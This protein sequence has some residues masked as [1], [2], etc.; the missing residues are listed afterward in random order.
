MDSVWQLYKTGPWFS[1]LFV[2]L[3]ARIAPFEWILPHLPPQGSLLEVGCGHGLLTNWIQ[4]HYPLCRILGTDVNPQRIAA[5]RQTLLGRKNIQFHIADGLESTKETYDCILFFDL[6]HH[7]EASQHL[8]S[9]RKARARL[10]PGGKIIVKEMFKERSLSHF[11]GWLHDKIVTQ[12]EK[13]CYRRAEEWI[14]L[15]GQAGL[16]LT[17]FRKGYKFWYHQ[18]LFVFEPGK[19]IFS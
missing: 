13:T 19:K 3:R 1:R 6:L 5:A 10:N 7:L 4:Q 15:A 8:S 9:L 16:Q 18:C 14:S 17:H 2:R 12:G 11:L